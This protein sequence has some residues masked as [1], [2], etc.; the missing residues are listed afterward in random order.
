ML[1]ENLK[2]QLKQYLDLLE[3]DLVL[4]LNADTSDANDEST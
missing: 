3:N 4:R 1:E 2:G